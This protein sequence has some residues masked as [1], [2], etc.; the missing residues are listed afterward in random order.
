MKRKIIINQIIITASILLSVGISFIAIFG[1]SVGQKIGVTAHYETPNLLSTADYADVIRV[2]PLERTYKT[3]GTLHLE[4]EKKTISVPLS[5]TIKVAVKATVPHGNTI[6]ENGENGYS[7][8]KDVL[9]LSLEK[10]AADIQLTYQVLGEDYVIFSA[11]KFYFHA[12]DSTNMVRLIMGDKK[13]I[14]RING[15]TLEGD[16]AVFVT[17]TEDLLQYS[18]EDFYIEVIKEIL[19][20]ETYIPN[21]YLIN[22]VGDNQYL[23]NICNIHLGKDPVFYQRT[24]KVEP[25]NSE[26]SI[27]TSGNVFPYEKVQNPMR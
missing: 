23:L 26:Y 25:F 22:A 3:T 19:F 21:A 5:A 12:F 20:N 27:I 8:D 17:R 7:V 6:Y 11:D 2:G 9:I 14:T 15:K 4:A 24:V 1:F 10:G 13:I 16:N 18:G